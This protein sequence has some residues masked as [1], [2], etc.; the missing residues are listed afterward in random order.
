MPLVRSPQLKC[1]SALESLDVSPIFLGGPP[2][3]ISGHRLCRFY[4]Q[5]HRFARFPSFFTFLVELR[6]NRCWPAVFRH[7]PDHDNVVIRPQSNSERI[8]NLKQLGA[9]RP[10]AVDLDFA[11]FDRRSSKRSRFE[12]ARGPQPFVQ[13]HPYQLV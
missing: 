10:L 11:R 13:A 6:R 8:A 9:F 5:L 2:S 4:L 7:C 1:I 3:L 12:E